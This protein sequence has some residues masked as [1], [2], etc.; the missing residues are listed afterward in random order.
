MLDQDDHRQI[1][2]DQRL[3]HF[4]DEA[5]GMVFWHPR[6]L[7]LFRCLERSARGELARQDYREVRT[8][9]LMRQPIWELSG[10][11]Q[12]FDEGM[13][14]LVEDDARGVA[15]RPVNCPGH[16]QIYRQEI[17]SYR[18]LPLRL[19]EFGVVHRKEPS[20]ALQ[21]LFRLRE[22]TQDDGHV[23]CRPDQLLPELSR[24]CRSLRAFYRRFGFDEVIV[25]LSTRP[26]SRIG[27]DASW[28]RAEA[29]LASAASELGLAVVEQ[30]GEG[31]F[32]GPKL[33]FKLRDRLGRVWQCGT[34]QVD[35][36]MPERFDLEYADSDGA[37]R[38]PVMLHRALYGSVER[39]IGVLLGH[40]A[41]K[42]PT[43]LAP[44]QAHVLPVSA[45]EADYAGELALALRRSPVRVVLTTAEERLASRVAEA[46]R[47]GAAFVLVVGPREAARREVSM[48]HAG[49]TEQA[50]FDDAIARLSRAARPAD[51]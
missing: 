22:F 10:H 8:P 33:E 5:P 13:F 23:F 43:W 19:A 45:A 50:P 17:R 18:E 1:A 14:K 6:G 42:L 21:G 38:R 25:G 35:F 44:E 30:P 16:V 3:L 49:V 11:W 24:F 51:D 2:K 36:A 9:E 47:A 27:D 31:A 48:S 46:R 32:Y 12:H 28:D 34:I 40:Y 29:A 26:P 15:L 37:R 20:G 41:G 7:E 39:F 4:Q